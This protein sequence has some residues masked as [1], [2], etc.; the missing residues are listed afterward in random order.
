[1]Y[2]ELYITGDKHGSWDQSLR[3]FKHPTKYAVIIAGDA[4]FEY[5]YNDKFSPYGIDSFDPYKK[6]YSNYKH[7]I[8]IVLRGN[9]D[10]RYWKHIG[11]DKWSLTSIDGCEG[12]FLIENKYPN[13][14]YV[15]DGGGKYNIFGKK[16]LFIP[17]AF[18]IDG[19]YRKKFDYPY[20]PEEQLNKKEIDDLL[21]LI[22]K[23]NEYD[24]IVSHT[25]PY[26]IE[27]KIEKYFLSG[28]FT[29][30]KNMEKFLQAVDETCS[31]KK[32]YFGH[33]HGDEEI[34]DKHHL[35]F[36]NIVKL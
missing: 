15:N 13:I 29:V 16:I 28:S 11:D 27:K 2:P 20:E 14:L 23:D 5:G 25:Y 3:F 9:H 24:Y 26:N 33:L 12:E 30:D 22:E 17:G 35:L 7:V 8:W 1:M 32:W 21:D 6:P 36:H 10:N 34:D 18:S 19:E 4:G 31:Y